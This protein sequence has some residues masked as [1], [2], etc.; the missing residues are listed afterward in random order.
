[1][2]WGGLP[3][4]HLR[5]QYVARPT[6]LNRRWLMKALREVGRSIERL[7]AGMTP[8]DLTE[9]PSDDE[10]CVAEIVG[11]MRD[12]DREDLASINAI[13]A[14]DSAR[15]E[16]RRAQFGPLEHD[17]RSEPIVDLLWD[18]ATLREDM[19]WT[20]RT[21]GAEDWSRTGQHPYRGAVSLSQLVREINERDL[22]AMWR[23]RAIRDQLH[24]PAG[25]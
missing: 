6:G 21:T 3:A 14:R 4:Y 17:Y 7:T 5:V 16:E 1:M 12:S 22:D 10:W 13:L 9:R 23:I 24:I 20:L 18:F 25:H 2:P 19:V 8:P 15:I 11:F